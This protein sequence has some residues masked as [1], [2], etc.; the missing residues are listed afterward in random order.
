M[1]LVRVPA[2]RGWSWIVEGW[3]LF[4]KAPGI[5]VLIFLIY[6]AISFV[7]SLIPVL[8]ELAYA[9][10]SPVLAGG[11]FYGAARLA[12]GED[13]EVRHLFQGFRERTNP[14]VLL[15]LF[16]IAGGVIMVLIVLVLM[17]GS[18]LTG[19]AL[20]SAT[21]VP[22]TAVGGIVAGA[23]LI[24]F[25]LVLSVA[26]I[27]VMAMFYGV[28]L[29]MLGQQATWPAIMTSIMACWINTVPF[30]VFGLTYLALGVL[31]VMTFGLGFLVLGPVTVCAIYASYR[32]VFEI[33]ATPAP[34]V[35]LNK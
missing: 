3:Q 15:G 4:I 5:W 35:R 33:G 8:G 21:G 12:A 16:S 9:L 11:M 20:G 26:F 7:L 19:M 25:L 2:G 30:L 22:D 31:A 18:V 34:T 10:L 6:L 13:L 27:V 28:P 23:G 1:E 14:L 17:G 32:E 24:T 29:I